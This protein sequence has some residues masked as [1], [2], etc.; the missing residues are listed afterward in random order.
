[1]S[2]EVDRLR[3]LVRVFDELI[4]I[5]GTNVRVGLDPLMGIL[6]GGD[7]IGGV[8]AA[9]TIIVAGRLGAPPAVIARMLLNVLT[10]TLIGSIPLAGDLFDVGYK[11]NRRNVE[12][13]EQY[14]RSPGRARAS[15]RLVVGLAILI[16]IVM[17]AGAIALAAWLT[18]Q[19]ISLF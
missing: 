15:S 17:V 9:W 18:R 8:F 10:D 12:L 1:M 3:T 5:P 7:A 6:P 11:A 19:V 4:R 13:L 2:R 16:L 14:L